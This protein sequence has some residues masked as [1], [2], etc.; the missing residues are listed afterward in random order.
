MKITIPSKKIVI[1][2][3]L[4]LN[5]LATYA[6][7]DPMYTH[8]MYNTLAVNPAYAGSREALTL[9]GLYRNQWVGFD[10]APKNIT[11]TGHTP[12]GNALGLGVSFIN[13]KIGPIT[14][15][16]I[17]ADLAY[18]LKL[19]AKSKLAFGLKG[20]INLFSGN[21]TQLKTNH[22]YNANTPSDPATAL[23]NVNNSLTPNLGAGLYYYR[24]RFYMGISAPK[25]LQNKIASTE[26]NF[27]TKTQTV[28]LID[29]RLHYF[30]IIGTILD[31]SPKVQLKPTAL[32]KVTEA[33][34]VEGDFTA[35]FIFA[36][37]FNLGAMYRTGDAIG[38]LLGF[39]I[40]SQW[41]I[42][43][44]YDWSFVSKTGF[45]STA[46][47]TGSHE[48]MMRYDLIYKDK[49]KIKSPRYF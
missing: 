33:A 35:Q 44:S 7:Q 41:T 13:D 16:Q 3:V 25:L 47:N 37:K 1:A 20:G 14:N 18:H 40:T 22:Q 23:G 45:N 6:Q 8:Y 30:G 21:L 36:E 29:E 32:L 49:A 39:N 31:L 4:G 34:P 48:V 46:Y 28:N 10:G 12:I 26:V 24:D 2:L 27:N 9:T 17:Y 42:G 19:N 11:F 38:A 5:T 15:N 43:Y